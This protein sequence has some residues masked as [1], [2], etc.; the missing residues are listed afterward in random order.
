MDKRVIFAVAGSGKTS[1]IVKKIDEEHRSL[2]L[3]YTDNN[4][5]NIKQ[6]ILN[7]FGYIPENIRVQSYFKFLYSF[8]YRPFLGLEVGAKGI[9]W[10]SPPFFTLRLPRHL[11]KFYLDANGRLY[12][13]RI[14]KLLEQRG[15]MTDVVE[16]IEKYYD[17]LFIDEIQDFAGHDFNFLSAIAAA[18]LN[19]LFVGD[20]FQHTY[21]TSRDGTVNKSLH[22][23]FDV[24]KKKFLSMGLESDSVTLSKSYRC[25]PT[26][27]GFI[28]A[29]LD[30]SIDSHRDD[31]TKIE[32][33]DCK[34]KALEIFKCGDRVKLFYQNCLKYP[35]YS[36]NWGG[37]KGQDCY[38]DVCVVLNPTTFKLYK[39]G[40]LN[41]LNP[42]TKN[43]FYVACTR[44]KNHLYF[45]PED[46]YKKFKN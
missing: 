29:N 12:H 41:E 44:A 39:K 30:I 11:T 46:L 36:A 42:K 20:C 38:D 6:K 3:T 16:R 33:I 37:S 7:K 1:H 26:V 23:D 17:N 40:Q 28:S 10:E 9:N 18:N 13:N 2:I 34:D 43:K 35:C 31:E 5:L 19:I 22:D 24:Y 32:F 4:I 45:V 14:A 25:S 27:C 15:V 21:D 8:C